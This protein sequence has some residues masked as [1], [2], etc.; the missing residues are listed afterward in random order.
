MTK[1]SGAQHKKPQLITYVDRLA[2]DLSGLHKLL[3]SDLADVFAGVHLLPFYDPMDGADAGFDPRNHG[4][5][6]PRLGTWSD[7]SEIAKGHTVM[8]DLIVNH[9]SA[10]SEQFQDWQ[11]HGDSSPYAGMFLTIDDVFPDGAT[12]ELLDQIYRPR[13]SRPFTNYEIDGVTRQLWTTFTGAQVDLNMHS[14]AAWSYL[15]S[16]LDQFAASGVEMVRLDAAGYAIKKPGTSCF[17]IPETFD[18]IQRVSAEANRRGMQ[19]LVE[20]HSHHQFQIQLAQQVDLVYDFALPP[21]VLHAL[22][23]GDAV[24]LRTWLEIAPRN[25]V[26]VLDTHDGIGIVDAAAEKDKP[27][28]LADDAID[29]L[30]EAIHDASGGRSRKATGAAAS[31]LDLYQ[32]N[33]S[34]YEALGS[35]DGAYFFARLVQLLC[36]GIPQIYYG[37]LLAAPNDMQLLARTSVGR[38]IN[39]PYYQPTDLHAAIDRPIVR[40]LLA[41]VRWRNAHS[42]VFDGQFELLDCGPTELALRWSSAQ[43]VLEAHLDAATRQFRVDLDGETFRAASDFGSA[44]PGGLDAN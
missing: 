42:D 40:E 20:I 25:C 22:H 11:R 37:G 14:D 38:D 9:V 35:D 39:R 27:G 16:V 6:D 29:A 33:C 18:F 36:P 15:M 17:M 3:D 26:T 2:G 21:L 5:V 13:P 7:V 32:V 34:F 44:Q 31:N 24:P 28:L 43:H 12:D 1:F 8:A 30:V 23:T 10:E 41:L 19:V 4:V